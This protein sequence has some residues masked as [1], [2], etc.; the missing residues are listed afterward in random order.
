MWRKF[1]FQPAVFCIIAGELICPRLASAGAASDY[2]TP[3]QVL[4]AY[5][6]P[7]E[8]AAALVIMRD[9]VWA[10]D[11]E[12]SAPNS[13]PEYLLPEIRGVLGGAGADWRAAR[14]AAYNAALKQVQAQEQAQGTQLDWGGLTREQ[15]ILIYQDKAR[16][17]KFHEELFQKFLPTL[18]A[19]MTE[20]HW[21]YGATLAVGILI[22]GLT[23]LGMLILPWLLLPEENYAS[24]PGGSGVENAAAVTL[25]PELR[26]VELPR[27]RYAVALESGLVVDEKTWSETRLHV[28]TSGGQAY[29]S[30]GTAYSP[31]TT[32]V[33]PT[34]VNVSSTVTQK[35]RIWMRTA[36]GRELSWTFSDGD[37]ITRRSQVISVLTPTGNSER[38]TALLAFNH[39][40]QKLTTLGRRALKARHSMPMRR[41]WL[42][43]TALGSVGGWL[44]AYLVNGRQI[45]SGSGVLVLIVLVIV[46]AVA[47]G[48]YAWIIESIY[49]ARRNRRFNQKYEP[50][51]RQWLEKITPEL[52]RRFQTSG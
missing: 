11:A 5:P 2:P 37:L 42:A 44:I 26:V 8:S 41:P 7:P 46:A 36:D 47:A 27:L 52:L 9:V 38:L 21:S 45:W 29:V 33:T 10:S 15:R 24:A 3:Q 14:L 31:A 32:H 19:T 28:S 1:L 34:Q 50:A 51:F 39:T 25:P 49:S 18:A 43:T 4:Q 12:Q 23:L 17:R 13:L 30:G 16:S 35:D 48:I 6:Q 40:T 20:S 22:L